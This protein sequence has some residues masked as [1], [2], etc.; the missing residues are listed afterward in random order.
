M[1]LLV[2]ASISLNGQTFHTLIHEGASA[3]QLIEKVAKE[4]GGGVAKVYYPE[5]KT[6]EIVAVKV[7]NQLLV[8]NDPK[9]VA[10]A[11]FS[12]FNDSDSVKKDAVSTA[13][14]STGGIHFFVGK[15]GIPMAAAEDDGEYLAKGQ[16]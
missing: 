5:F 10:E 3:E 13:S 9:R 12:D 1:P 15:D 4:N 8:K 2:K 7:G 11:D 14:S 16:M 6:Y